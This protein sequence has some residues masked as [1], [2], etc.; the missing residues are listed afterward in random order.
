MDV[1]VPLVGLLLATAP[2]VVLGV[3]VGGPLDETVTEGLLAQSG[4]SGEVVLDS[5]SRPSSSSLTDSAADTHWAKNR[6]KKLLKSVLGAI[7]LQ[8]CHSLA[9]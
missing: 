3:D 7:K 2:S 1:R 8:Y 4:L 6:N 5:V 9:S